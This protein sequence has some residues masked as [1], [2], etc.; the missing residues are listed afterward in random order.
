MQSYEKIAKILRTDK[1]TVRIAGEE[2]AKIVGHNSVM[3]KIVQE[4]EDRKQKALK[5]LN[6]G[7]SCK[8]H[9]HP[10]VDCASDIFKALTDK[11]K[12][13]D[14]KLMGLIHK[15]PHDGQGGFSN[16]LDV[17]KEASHV[18]AGK[19]LKLEK[20]RELIHLNPPVAT[21]KYL[22]YAGVDELLM[23]EDIFEIFA[24][25]RFLEDK[26]WLNDVFFK[27]Y[28]NLSYNDFEE[29][30][31]KTKV[32]SEKFTKAADSF[33]K[34]KYH[35]LSHLKELGLIFIIPIQ[36]DVPGVTMRDFTLALHY[37]H[38]VKFY[39]DLFAKY[40]ESAK[41][42]KEFAAKFVSGLR[43]DAIDIRPPESDLGKKWLIIQ[44]YLAKDDEFDWRLFYPHVNPEALHWQKAERDVAELSRRFDLGFEFWEG[45][46][47]T[48]DFYK[49]ESGV[50]VLVSF[51]LIDTAMG[52]FME[53]QLVKYLYHHQEA[54]WNKIFSGYFG[55]EKMERMIIENFDKGVIGV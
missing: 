11:I 16:M 14:E 36:I 47:T 35:N 25:L 31:I 52:L 37:F 24:A 46:G 53:K 10:H 32:I 38:E 22:G 50:E 49:D 18:G 48:G 20:A 40:A 5:D 39:S 21:M 26:K 42:D 55:E 33:L 17:A 41:S 8:E 3:D 29:R 34:K 2:L 19:F 43:G 45:L 44:S 6:L 9:G 15:R 27:P 1:D 13:D 54:L 7:G 12:Q 30:E 23:K 51:N 4:N 28:E